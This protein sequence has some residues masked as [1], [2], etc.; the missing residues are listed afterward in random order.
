MRRSSTTSLRGRK[1]RPRSSTIEVDGLLLELLADARLGEAKRA[2]RGSVDAAAKVKVDH[3]RHRLQ[4][5]RVR[6][7]ARR[8]P[9]VDEIAELQRSLE[10]GAA[11]WEVQRAC[12]A[13]AQ[14]FHLQTESAM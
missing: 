10:R 12:D 9:G 8:G 13:V 4:V 1:L 2:H 3:H 7:E 11:A 5:E 14:E 6:I